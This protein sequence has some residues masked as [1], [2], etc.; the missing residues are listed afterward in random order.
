MN[1]YFKITV[2]LFQLL[3][4]VNVFS[5]GFI[6]GTRVKTPMGHVAIE[7]I[8]VNDHV[9]C[10]DSNNKMVEKPVLFVGKKSVLS[11]AQIFLDDVCLVSGLDQKFYCASQQKWVSVLG[12]HKDD[13]LIARDNRLC[14]VKRIEFIDEPVE[15]YYLL[16]QDIH[17]FCVSELEIV[18]HNFVPVVAAVVWAFG[19]GGVELASIGF[20]FAGGAFLGYSAYKKQQ[21][22]SREYTITVGHSAHRHDSAT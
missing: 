5:E 21:R 14:T 8:R 12:L 9:M 15:L 4:V 13:G 6:A 18:A 2:L 20:G 10:W 16:V 3:L 19:L 7:N 17:N 1:A 22:Q 11:H